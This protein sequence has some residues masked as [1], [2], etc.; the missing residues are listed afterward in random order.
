MLFADEAA[1][2]T[3]TE[4]LG[5]TGGAF[6]ILFA[7]E[8]ASEVFAESLGGIGGAF[9]MLFAGGVFSEASA[10]VVSDDLGVLVASFADVAPD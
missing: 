4:S 2:E 3:F 9:G 7:D 10:V 1:S 5:G 6:G 8:A